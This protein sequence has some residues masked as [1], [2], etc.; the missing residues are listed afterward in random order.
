MIKDFLRYYFKAQTAHGLHSPFVFDFYNQVLK[1]PLKPI[2]KIESLR[3]QLLKDSRLLEISDL[4]APSK[5]HNNETRKVGSI[6]KTSA[7]T[8]RHAFLLKK[9]IEKYNYRIVLDL[10]TSLGLTT[11]YLAS[12][13]SNPSVY[14]FEG[15]NDVSDVAIYNFRKCNLNNITLIKGNIDQTLND[16]L[17]KENPIIDFVFFDAN[18]KF[19]PTIDYFNDCLPYVHNYSCF[20][21]DDIYWSSEMKK[22]WTY[23]I[24]HPK[25]I[26]TIDIFYLGIVFFDNSRTKQHFIL[27]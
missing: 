24:N 23:L 15:N 3:N 5:F 19:Q 17:R 25:C 22:A 26:T 21:F 1:S 16:F 20:V 11:A 13:D 2:E 12:A 14:T 4:G 10:G 27:K 9:I 8:V 18:H 7:K 6:A